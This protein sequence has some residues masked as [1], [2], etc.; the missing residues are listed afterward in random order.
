MQSNMRKGKTVLMLYN[1][2]ELS[3]QNQII[4]GD[5]GTTCHLCALEERDVERPISEAYVKA[6]EKT[7]GK[8]LRVFPQLRD[9]SGWKICLCEKHLKQILEDMQEDM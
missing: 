3:N 9:T 2:M 5:A 8:R 7:Y 6:T 4:L 1:G